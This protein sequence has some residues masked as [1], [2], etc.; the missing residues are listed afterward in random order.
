MTI[1]HFVNTSAVNDSNYI[2]GFLRN[3]ERKEKEFKGMGSREPSSPFSD[4]N[5]W[6]MDLHFVISEMTNAWAVLEHLKSGLNP[7]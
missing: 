7:K 6:V 4:C 5:K 1:K 3:G 2:S